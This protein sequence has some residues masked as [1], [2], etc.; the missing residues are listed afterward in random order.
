MTIR[1]QLGTGLAGAVVVAALVA[2]GLGAWNLERPQH[3]LAHPL[4][5]RTRLVPSA[6]FFGDPFVA[7]VAVDLDP[8]VVA[9]GS[10]RVEPS[11]SPY[12]QSA[13]TTVD[14]TTVG[15]QETIGTATR[16]SVSATAAC[17]SELG[18]SSGSPSSW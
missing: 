16:F 15:G 6:A 12:V 8:A 1:T 2:T 10:V 18:A 7:Q 14:R 9:P 11:F 13:P 5:V 4:A 17:R 3:A